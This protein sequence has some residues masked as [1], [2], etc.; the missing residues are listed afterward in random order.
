MI[1]TIKEAQGA[2][3]THLAGSNAFW[4]KVIIGSL[5]VIAVCIMTMPTG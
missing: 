1:K 2:L 3:D 5:I 4:G